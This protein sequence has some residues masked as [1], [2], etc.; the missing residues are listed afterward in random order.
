MTFYTDPSLPPEAK[1]KAAQEF[2]TSLDI[3]NDQMISGEEQ[4]LAVRVSLEALRDDGS[5]NALK[6]FE[7]HRRDCMEN[8]KAYADYLNSTMLEMIREAGLRLSDVREFMPNDIQPVTDADVKAGLHNMMSYGELRK[9]RTKDKG[10]K[11]G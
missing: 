4:V 9:E 1:R 8:P 5:V 7:Q 6:V 11:W 3:N 10:D 2:L